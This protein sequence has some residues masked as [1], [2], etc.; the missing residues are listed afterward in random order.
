MST[1]KIKVTNFKVK[2]PD[3]YKIIIFNSIPEQ[4]TSFKYLGCENSYETKNNVNTKVH[5]FQ[6]TCNTINTALK[7]NAKK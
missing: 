4:V 7:R 1:T 3:R 5:Q 2:Q 6:A